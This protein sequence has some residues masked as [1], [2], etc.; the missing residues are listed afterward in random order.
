MININTH[1]WIFRI[2]GG[3]AILFGLLTLKSGGFVLFVDGPDRAAAGN[4]VPFVLWFNF[5]AGFFYILAGIGLLQAR[6]WAGLLSAVIALVTLLVFLALGFHISQGGAYETRTVGAMVLR[7]S[8]WA[9]IAFISNLI[10]WKHANAFAT[11]ER[12]RNQSGETIQ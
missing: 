10:F 9:A 2:M 6:R 7:S 8:I 12:Q 3:I 1:P 5:I 11:V 4:F